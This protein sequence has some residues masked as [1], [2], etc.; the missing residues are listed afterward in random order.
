MLGGGGPV[1]SLHLKAVKVYGWNPTGKNRPSAYI[2]LHMDYSSQHASGR[3][4]TSKISNNYLCLW[5]SHLGNYANH[6]HNNTV[7]KVNQQRPC[8]V[9]INVYKTPVVGAGVVGVFPLERFQ[10]A[11]TD[12]SCH[13]RLRDTK[14]SARPGLTVNTQVRACSQQA[15]KSAATCFSPSRNTQKQT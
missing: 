4:V 13:F 3:W 6:V 8:R 12:Y 10:T 1:L 14:L 5:V 2:T 9:Y 11:K 7:N 15:F